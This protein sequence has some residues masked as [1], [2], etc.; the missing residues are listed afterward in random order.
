MEKESE[1]SSLPQS[2]A[3]GSG[4]K[5]SVTF[6]V[7]GQDE[8]E[9]SQ[10]LVASSFAAVPHYRQGSIESS[11]GSFAFSSEVRNDAD[12]DVSPSFGTARSSLG[13]CDSIRSS[14]IRVS[15]Y[16]TVQREFTIDKLQF[17]ALKELFGREREIDQLKEL[18]QSSAGATKQLVLIRGPSGAGKSV[19]ALETKAF[20]RQTAGFYIPGKFEMQQRDEPYSAIGDACQ[21]LCEDLLFHKSSKG[22]RSYNRWKFSYEEFV[23]ELKE[24]VDSYGIDLLRTV[25]PSLDEIVGADPMQAKANSSRSEV[26]YVELKQAFQHAFRRFIRL[27]ASFGPVVL[28]L[29]D[30]QWVDE[31]SMELI[32]SLITD[33]QTPSLIIIGSYRDNEVDENHVLTKM[34]HHLK[35]LNNLDAI[36]TDIEVGNLL[37]E[38]V[39]KMLDS[40]ISSGERTQSL[41][42]CVHRKTAGNAFFVKQFLLSLQQDRLLAFNFGSMRW[43]WDVEK[44][45]AK[46]MATDNVVDLLTA[47][48][49][50]LPPPIQSILP[51]VACLGSRFSVC[52]FQI[53]VNH[54]RTEAEVSDIVN[55]YYTKFWAERAKPSVKN[56]EKGKQSL[57]DSSSDHTVSTVASA[58]SRDVDR[59]KKEEYGLLAVCEE[60]EIIV[61][62]VK[63]G[64]FR[65]EHDR[66]QEAAF[67]LVDENE[68][69]SIQY[70]V[71]ELLLEKLSCEELATELYVVTNL[72]NTG[73]ASLSQ[74]STRRVEIAN[75]NLRSGHSAFAMSAFS[76]AADYLKKGIALL[77]PD[78]WDKHYAMT[79]EMYST[80]AEAAF[81]CGK[82]ELT[83]QLCD[84][85]LE[86]ENRPLLDKRR[87]YNVQIHSLNAQSQ[88]SSTKDLCVDVL[89]KLGCKFPKRGR[90]FYA[91][92]GLIRVLATLEST[93]NKISTLKA[94]RDEHKQWAMYL[95]DRLT[96]CTYQCDPELLPLS[97]MKGLRWTLKYGIADFTAPT[98]VTFG[99]MLAGSVGNFAGA[100][101]Y[102]DFAL[103]Y[104]DRNAAPRTIFLAY[105]FI[106]PWQ[107]PFESCK[108]PLLEAYEAGMKTGDLES[109]LWAIYSFLELQLFTAADLHHVLKDLDMYCR[110]MKKYNQEMILTS[111]KM[112]LQV[113]ANLADKTSKRHILQ[114]EFMDVQQLSK[115]LE[116]SEGNLHTRN[117]LNRY[118][119]LVAFWF[120][121]HEVV[122]ELMEDAQYHNFSIE[123]ATPCA[124]GIG[125]LYFH[126]ALSCISVARKSK[127]R[128]HRKRATK[129]LKKIKN[130]V[131]K[132]NPNLQHCESLIEAELASLSGDPQAAKKHYEV[133]ILL[134]GRWGLTNDHAL[135]HER[136]GD[137]ALRIGDENDARYHYSLALSLYGEWGAASKVEQL[138]SS[139]RNLVLP[140]GEIDV[141]SVVDSQMHLPGDWSIS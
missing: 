48:L 12:A 8:K 60:E 102:A 134:A 83:K 1:L 29:E 68:L 58:E 14:S 92:A 31:P 90:P 4:K 39:N 122:V 80:A 110:Q 21:N 104:M 15:N 61:Q 22:E 35:A 135:A 109:A 101:K 30:L 43:T 106:L 69:D 121:E 123:Q 86:S 88:T 96:N 47:K 11:S 127:Q 117:Q 133:A 27:V 51:H 131:K 116:G 103:K 36:I 128:K 75:L 53:V 137:Y 7:P 85:I 100:K 94:S 114:G 138:Q 23:T 95:L 66:I 54:Y 24:V 13:K 71:G 57:S 72:L 136:F 49:K 65:W 141:G 37:E 18:F 98:L 3:G 115:E 113:A 84:E 5:S 97:M 74:Q 139:I 33:E 6:S 82:H 140:I 118:K 59:K 26:N 28:V 119:T 107:I 25:I 19:L 17:S 38:D 40:L 70:D 10:P 62:N 64:F 42:E 130:W 50:Q 9:S 56:P 2:R 125:P 132:C 93:T 76:A 46:A 129:F 78:R 73:V 67:L 44:I 105:E 108:K 79:L 126:C 32:E 120:N 63:R 77:P 41:A 81:C 52:S 34:V 45:N 124:A 89:A 112:V 111:T 87:A 20:V 16:S 91:L 99:L 55:D